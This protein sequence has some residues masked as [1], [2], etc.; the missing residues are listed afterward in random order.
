MELPG[1]NRPF[2][3]RQVFVQHQLGVYL[4]LNPQ[5][6]AFTAGAVRR[7][8]AEGSGGNLA[9]A[10]PAVH[11]GKVLREQKLLTIDDRH[12]HHP[13]SQL[14]SRLHRVG[15]AALVALPHHQSV[16]HHLDRVFLILIK[17]KFLSQVANLAVNPNADIARLAQVAKHRLIFT[18]AATYQRG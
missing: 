10:D 14:D 8:K 12:Q 6:G 11:A 15:D 7:V 3:D 5:P 18:L 4:Q 2:Q 1:A 9:Q 13:R 17:L 16:N